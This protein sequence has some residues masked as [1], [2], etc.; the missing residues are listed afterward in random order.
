LNHYQIL[1]LISDRVVQIVSWPH[2]GREAFRA[3]PGQFGA[4]FDDST[5]EV[6]FSND[7]I[8]F[9]SQFDDVTLRK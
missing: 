6:G 1:E 3:F 8:D 5:T 2:F 4:K 7:N 9:S